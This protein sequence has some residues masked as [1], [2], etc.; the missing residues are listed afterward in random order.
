M[1]VSGYVASYLSADDVRAP[2][3]IF[4]SMVTEEEV[5]KESKLVMRG[6]TPDGEE[7]KI[8]L[9]KTN[10][11]KLISIFGTDESDEWVGEPVVA[12]RDPS[13]QFGGKAVGGIAFRKPKGDVSKMRPASTPS[14]SQHDDSQSADSDDI[15]F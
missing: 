12:W 9:N 2:K 4:I 14:N 13:V 3:L 11:Q 1:K 6:N 15:P 8:A 7:V 10:V 5:G